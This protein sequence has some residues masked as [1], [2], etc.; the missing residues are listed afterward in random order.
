MVEEVIQVT[1][2]NKHYKI[3]R[4]GNRSALCGI[5][6]WFTN[7]SAILYGPVWRL[8]RKHLFFGWVQQ[9]VTNNPS[10]VLRW[11]KEYLKQ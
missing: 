7:I 11:K 10:H 4:E 2:A 9:S 6:H 1:A 3:T 8:Y 5:G